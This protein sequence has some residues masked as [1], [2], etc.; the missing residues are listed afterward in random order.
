VFNIIKE[1]IIKFCSDYVNHICSNTIYGIY[2]I[3]LKILH[4]G[5]HKRLLFC[6]AQSKMRLFSGRRFGRKGIYQI[7]MIDLEMIEL[8]IHRILNLFNQKKQYN[9]YV[10]LHLYAREGSLFQTIKTKHFFNFHWFHAS[11]QLFSHQ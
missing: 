9:I 11:L 3:N 6:A 5:R 1:N 4:Q 8:I 10:I 2:E 7:C